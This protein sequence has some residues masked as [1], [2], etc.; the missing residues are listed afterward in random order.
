[1]TV[2]LSALADADMAYSPT[3]WQRQTFPAHLR[4]RIDVIHEGIDT[5]YFKPDPQAVFRIANKNVTLRA[6]DEV[7]TYAARSLEPVRGFHQFMRALPEILEKRPNAHVVIMG[8]EKTSY[9]LEPEDFGSWQDKLL[10]EVGHLLDPQR[11]HFTGFLPKEHYRTVLQVSK[12]H[13]YLTY[14]FLLSWSMLDAMACGAVIIGSD[15]GPVKE[16]IDDGKN[17][18]TV[19]FFDTQKLAQ[20]IVTQ[21]KTKP[22]KSKSIKASARQWMTTKFN[23]GECVKNMIELISSDTKNKVDPALNDIN[24]VRLGDILIR[25]HQYNEAFYLYLKCWTKQF[26]DEF[27]KHCIDVVQQCDNIVLPSK[28]VATLMRMRK[29]KQDVWLLMMQLIPRLCEESLMCLLEESGDDGFQLVRQALPNAFYHA[30]NIHDWAMPLMVLNV[31]DKTKRLESLPDWLAVECVWLNGQLSQLCSKSSK[32][33]ESKYKKAQQTLQGLLIWS[34]VVQF[35][36]QCPL[37]DVDYLANEI[38]SNQ[39]PFDSISCLSDFLAHPQSQTVSPHI[40]L[41]ASWHTQQA[42]HQEQFMNVQHVLID[43]FRYS[44]D[45]FDSIPNPN[46]YFDCDGYRQRYLG[47]NP[48]AH[49]LLHYLTHFNQQNVQPSDYFYNDYVRETQRLLPTQE[50]LSFY[51]QQLKQGGVG[52]CLNGFST[53]PYFDR[54]YYLAQNND[55]LSIVT[56]QLLDPLA[57]FISHG[58]KE[59]RQSYSLQ[60]YN[61]FAQHQRLYL[62]PFNRH[63]VFDS[64]GSFHHVKGKKAEFTYYQGQKLLAENLSYKPLISI[65]VPIYQV[66]PRFLEEMIQSVIAQTYGHWQLCLVDDASKRYRKEIHQ[67]LERYAL[68][69]SRIVYRLRTK[70]GHI[71]LTTNDCIQLAKGEFLALLDHDDLLTPDALYEVALALNH[72]DKLDILYS[73]EDKVDEWGVLSSPYYKPDWSPHSLWSRMYTCHL[74]VYRQSLVKSVGGFRVGF[75]G[76]QDFDLM[77]RCSEKTQQIHHISKV[78]YHW[79]SHAESTASDLGGEV[80]HYSVDT[81]YKAVK[82]ALKR[83]QIPVTIDSIRKTQTA[84]W[85]KPRVM[86]QPTVD[87]I[88]PSFNGADIL[89]MCLASIF[90]K[91]TYP[92]FTITVI[93]NNSYES[94]FFALIAHWEEQEPTRFQVIRDERPFNFSSINNSAVEKTSGDYLLF[95]NNDTEVITPDWLEG[96]LG[97]SQLEDVGAVGVKLLYP[98][99]TVQHAGVVMGIGGI[100][101]HAMKNFPRQAHGYFSH[102]ELVTNYTAVTAACLMIKREKFNAAGGFDEHLQI[103]FNDIDFCLKVREQSL[104]NVYLPFV[105]LYHHESKSRGY[106]NTSKKQARFEQEI[107]FMRQRWGKLL[108]NDPFYSPWLSLDKEDMRYRF[109]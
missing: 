107:L 22:Y 46:P 101:G 87:I 100:A 98:D 4:E 81:G 55:L 14:P 66:Q 80:K 47:D 20:T 78:L 45:Y 7:I 28:T 72:N 3:Q 76:S 26:E 2:M 33:D 49:P 109:H 8:G 54:A 5:T 6:G 40:L 13:V 17:G 74:T 79:R 105:E 73:D 51:L 27:L 95:L 44:S 108:D 15:T 96:M 30:E 39:T 58:S 69:D 1:N 41:S 12:V 31:L 48:N 36:Q 52:F 18:F 67:L 94:D 70:N 11:V 61:E 38:G 102:L 34:K 88:I 60:A 37:L 65:L 16:I 50:P 82:D 59:G 29:H 85:V 106:E 89:E 68:D 63:S 104:F 53:T 83:R 93:D 71:C 35:D 10:A 25:Q 9:G 99:D 75:E 103:A 21:L 42:Q 56:M 62:E 97:Y 23:Q 92:H 64:N 84:F 77:L 43:F 90:E 91:T 86:N 24:P 32:T 57:H 19:P